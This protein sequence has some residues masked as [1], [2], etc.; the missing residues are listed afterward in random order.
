MLKL[1]VSVSLQTPQDYGF[2]PLYN[3]SA[4]YEAAHSSVLCKAIRETG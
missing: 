4:Y 2:D 3:P 1:F